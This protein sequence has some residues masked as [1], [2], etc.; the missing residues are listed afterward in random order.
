EERAAE[1]ARGPHART[2]GEALDRQMQIDVTS[3]EAL[4][5]MPPTN[6]GAL[7]RLPRVERLAL[8]LALHESSEQHALDVELASLERAWREAEEIAVIADN[9]LVPNHIEAG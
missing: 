8:E 4:S 7:F 2:L 5:K 9:L 1:F 6:R 3:R